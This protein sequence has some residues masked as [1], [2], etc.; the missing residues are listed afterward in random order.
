MGEKNWNE[1][2]VRQCRGQKKRKQKGVTKR[3]RESE[4]EEKQ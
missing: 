1:T 2:R 3:K 4:R